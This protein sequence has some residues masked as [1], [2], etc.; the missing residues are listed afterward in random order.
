ML[1]SCAGGG[2]KLGANYWRE[3]AIKPPSD[4]VPLSQVQ[5]ENNFAW[6]PLSEE[7]HDALVLQCVP[8]LPAA[9]LLEGRQYLFETGNLRA[10]YVHPGSAGSFWVKGTQGVCVR[11]SDKWHPIFPA[12]MFEK[13][14]SPYGVP[15]EQVFDWY[16]QIAKAIAFNGRARVAYVLQ[17][18]QVVDALYWSDPTNLAH[19]ELY[20]SAEVKEAGQ[21]RREDY[22]FLFSYPDMMHVDAVLRSGRY[23]KSM[24]DDE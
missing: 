8:T 22:T 21:W 18:G 2:L 16:R 23:Y 13:T 12:E 20:Y 19:A 14:I 11:Q 24:L 17:N 4:Y 1:T 5:I 9:Q 6:A 7:N 15:E 10:W 3:Q